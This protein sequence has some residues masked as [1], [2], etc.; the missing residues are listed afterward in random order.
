MRGLTD[1]EA[2]ALRNWLGSEFEKVS[3]GESESAGSDGGQEVWERGGTLVRLTRDHGRW[4]CDLSRTGKNVWL[5]IDR[6]AAAMGYEASVPVVRVAEVVGSMNDRVFDT[7]RAS[8]PH[9][10]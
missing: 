8:L 10:P 7:L 2:D 5:G 6:I 3:K 4:S 1:E 9:S